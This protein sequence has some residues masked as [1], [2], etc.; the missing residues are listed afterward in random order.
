V[1]VEQAYILHR[2]LKDLG[3]ETRLVV[4]PRASHMPSEL[5]HRLDLLAR[6]CDWMAGHLASG[7][8]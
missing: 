4:Y 6:V 1:P 3:V 5:A 7:T 8:P 2:A